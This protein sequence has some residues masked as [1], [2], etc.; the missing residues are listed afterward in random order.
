MT[1]VKN[2]GNT[3]NVGRKP[4]KDPAVFRYAVKLNSEENGRFEIMFQQSGLDR[5][6]KFIKAKVFGTPLKVVHIDK[7]TKDYYMLLTNFYYQFQAVGNN[8]NQIVRALKS[9][10]NEKTAVALLHRLEKKTIEMVFL[11][12]QIIAITK[13]Y[14]QKYLDQK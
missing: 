11:N 9:N 5:Y 1:E 13:E 14:E 10:F 8:Y 3:K 7:S 6:S 2:L 4:K 12:Q